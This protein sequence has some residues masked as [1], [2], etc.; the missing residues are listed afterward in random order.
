[1]KITD[2][3]L[4]DAN[5]LKFLEEMTGNESKCTKE[6]LSKLIVGYTDTDGNHVDGMPEFKSFFLESIRK[7]NGGAQEVQPDLYETLVGDDTKAIIEAKESK[8]EAK[9]AIDTWLKEVK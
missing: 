7:I 4:L 9:I 8:T 6:N 2:T 5:Q 3:R 1:M